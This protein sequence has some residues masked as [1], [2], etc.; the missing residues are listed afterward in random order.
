MSAFFNGGKFPTPIRPSRTIYYLMGDGE[1]IA[2][3]G[4][5]ATRELLPAI[6]A[7]SPSAPALGTPRRSQ[8]D[9]TPRVLTGKERRWIRDTHW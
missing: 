1:I 5:S 9:Y 6:H 8:H 3:D 4:P 7:W 2:R